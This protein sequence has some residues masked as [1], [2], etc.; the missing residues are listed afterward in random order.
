[1]TFASEM[2]LI[3]DRVLLSKRVS[4]WNISFKNRTLDLAQLPF[5]GKMLA[6]D[7]QYLPTFFIPSGNKLG[8]RKN[9]MSSDFGYAFLEN[10]VVHSGPA[11]INYISRN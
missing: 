5:C 7:I 9:I 11:L 6:L 3:K 2:L 1:M 10:K 4:T 8:L